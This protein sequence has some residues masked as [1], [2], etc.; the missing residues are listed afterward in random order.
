M[1][2]DIE[3]V[4]RIGAGSTFRFDLVIQATAAPSDLT[5]A[6]VA[7][8]DLAAAP[9]GADAVTPPPQ[10][11]ERLHALA[12]EGNMRD[13]LHWAGRLSEL[14]GQRYRHFALHVRF[15]AER[16]QSQA[17]LSLAKRCLGTPAE[18]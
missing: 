9:A 4:S 15:L 12:L 1:G 17:I 13:I 6:A 5:S 14:E 2:S 11:I 10:E 18:G 16:Y 7:T 3:V 8:P